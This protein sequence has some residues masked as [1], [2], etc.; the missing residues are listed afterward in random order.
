[1]PL[2]QGFFTVHSTVG[3]LSAHCALHAFEQFG[4]L[5]MHNHGDKWAARRGFKPGTSRLKAPLDTNEP[6]GRPG[7]GKGVGSIF[8]PPKED[9]LPCVDPSVHILLDDRSVKTQH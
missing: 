4:T 5:Y 7:N 1:M 2:P 8:S 9:T 6:S 3:L